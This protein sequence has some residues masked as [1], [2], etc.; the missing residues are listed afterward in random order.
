MNTTAGNGTW[1]KNSAMKAATA[2]VHAMLPFNA[3][4]PIRRTAST[5]NTRTALFRPK[6]RASITGTWP[7]SA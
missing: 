2:S 6:N 7:A 4:R 3:R 5:T 1:R